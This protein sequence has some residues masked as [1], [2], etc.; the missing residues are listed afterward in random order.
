MDYETERV[1]HEWGR[2]VQ[3]EMRRLI[4]DGMPPM[5]AAGRARDNVSRRRR[6]ARMTPAD[7]VAFGK[8][9]NT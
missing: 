8:T 1:V 5:D 4:R 7:F 6:A 9:Y 3:A 2:E